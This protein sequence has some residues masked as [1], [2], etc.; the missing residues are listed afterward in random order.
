MNQSN[1]WVGPEWDAH[2]GEFLALSLKT[3]TPYFAGMPE[4]H[5]RLIVPACSTRAALPN[6][7]AWPESPSPFRETDPRFR[8]LMAELTRQTDSPAVVGNIGAWQSGATTEI[9]NSAEFVAPDGRFVG[10]YD[11]IHLVPFGEYVPYKGLIAFAGTLTQ[12]VGSFSRGGLRK[13]LHR[14]WSYLWR[15]YLL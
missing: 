1:D 13:G 3:C 2:T 6:L 14:G 12:G 7:V 11:K 9:F 10:R 8:T 15:L 4:P 5:P